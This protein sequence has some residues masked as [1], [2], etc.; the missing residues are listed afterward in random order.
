MLVKQPRLLWCADLSARI[1]RVVE[2]LLRIHPSK[3]VG[4]VSDI[5]AEYPELLYRMVRTARVFHS[6][7]L[8]L[9]GSFSIFILPY[10]TIPGCV[11]LP[12]VVVL[13]RLL[14]EQ[15]K[16]ILLAAAQCATRNHAKRV[17]R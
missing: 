8:P 5:V 14:S 9:S 3:D 16:F 10:Y 4:V 13:F 11:Y 15:R 12:Y 17:G 2:Q 7:N 6:V 1:E